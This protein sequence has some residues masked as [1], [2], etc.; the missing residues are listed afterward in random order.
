MRDDAP[1][2]VTQPAGQPRSEIFHSFRYRITLAFLLGAIFWLGLEHWLS[3]APPAPPA[4]LFVAVLIALSYSPLRARLPR[5]DALW[6]ALLVAGVAVGM[7]SALRLA[8]MEV[9]PR[10]LA[11]IATVALPGADQ[12]T[13][14]VLAVLSLGPLVRFPVVGAGWLRFW[15]GASITLL[16]LSQIYKHLAGT[17]DWLLSGMN[18]GE[19]ALLLAL[20][21]NAMSACT[22][23]RRLFHRQTLLTSLIYLVVMW[24]VMSEAIPFLMP[25]HAD[26][27]GFAV[28]GGVAVLLMAGTQSLLRPMELARHRMNGLALDPVLEPRE[29][30]VDKTLAPKAEDIPHWVVRGRWLLRDA[31]DA[32]RS[33]VVFALVLAATIGSMYF[34]REA[35]STIPTIWLPDMVVMMCLAV[36][37]PRL[38]FAFSMTAL[39]AVL[40]GVRMCGVDGG[41]ALVLPLGSV[42]SAVLFVAAQNYLN[43]IRFDDNALLNVE[44]K[45]QRSLATVVALLVAVIAVSAMRAAMTADMV[46]RFSEQLMMW[47]AATLAGGL[48]LATVSMGV[49]VAFQMEYRAP[50]RSARTDFALIA[51]IVGAF[52]A[53]ATFHGSM[54]LDLEGVRFDLV[55]IVLLPVVSA[56]SVVLSTVLRMGMAVFLGSVVFLGGAVLS[57]HSE[58]LYPEQLLVGM[59]ALVPM[60]VAVQTIATQSRR[61][62]PALP[63]FS[64]KTLMLSRNLR[65]LS[66]SAPL[67]GYLGLDPELVVGRLLDRVFPFGLAGEAGERLRGKLAAGAGAFSEVIESRSLDGEVRHFLLEVSRA[68]GGGR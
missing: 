10:A 54:F 42:T 14:G 31:P 11:R 46:H 4:V 52:G 17:D 21:L 56:F 15:G 5:R 40:I 32:L 65:I 67:S 43:H 25:D 39:A 2:Y 66:I 13:L 44:I 45:A 24:A 36:S 1:V 18:A 37:A 27:A 26:S 12:A 7:W 57:G 35:A 22:F 50:A 16:M 59:S 49:F 63:M 38:W 68:E 34:P 29:A 33:L 60:M 62:P 30:R 55:L 48:S 61:M 28:L 58:G 3:E 23:C 64:A 8:E 51:V 19:S 47:S 53:L 20:V 9:L 41:E 6:T